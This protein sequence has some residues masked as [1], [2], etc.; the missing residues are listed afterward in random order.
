[1]S[2]NSNG[3]LTMKT[4]ILL[5]LIV[6]LMGGCKTP[7]PC[8]DN[9]PPGNI[10]DKLNTGGDD[11]LPVFLDNILYF[12]SVREESNGKERIYKSSLIDGDFESPEKDTWLPLDIL[13]DAI[14]PSFYK[15]KT[16]GF[17]DIYFAAVSPGKEQNND[18]YHSRWN[19]ETWSK[20]DLVNS[21]ISSPYYESHPVIAPDGS[22]M[23]FSSDREGGYGETDLYVSYRL[24]ENKWSKAENLG[25][26]INTHEKEI[27]PAI[28]PDGSLYF[29]SKGYN[30]ASGYDIARARPAKEN[31]KWQQAVR[32]PFPVNTVFD[33]SGP[34]LYD[35]MILVSSNREGGCGAFDIYAFDLCGPVIIEGIVSKETADLPING[36]VELFDSEGKSLGKQDIDEDDN[37]FSFRIK[38]G[39]QYTAKYSNS[40]MPGNTFDKSFTAPCSDSTTVKLILDFGVRN[41]LNLFTFENY[42]VPFFVSGY[43]LPNTKENLESLKLKFSYNILGNDP[44]KKY[45]ENPGDDYDEYTEVVEQALADAYEFLESKLALLSGKCSEGNEKLVV[46]ITGYTDPRV[47]TGISKYDGPSIDEFGLQV[48]NGAKMNNVLLSQLRAYYTAKIFQSKLES[49]ENYKSLAERVIWIVF[50]NGNDDRDD[51]PEELKRRVDIMVGLEKQPQVD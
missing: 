27:A 43:Y 4:V 29:A 46:K 33:D 14:S 15:D 49:D 18:I 31:G 37:K 25:E 26:N 42:K 23:V 9:I 24:D 12:T 3:M 2:F 19:G 41:E 17:I 36:E 1:M 40:C 28:G 44:G 13:D 6:V 51:I 7:S 22:F 11:H 10:G 48:E 5:L 20:P 21:G 39:Y 16:T 47:I 45:I 34:A 35:N 30:R 32:M 8:P 50:G 38:P